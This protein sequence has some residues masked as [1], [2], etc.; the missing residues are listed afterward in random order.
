MLCA[1]LTQLIELLLDRLGYVRLELVPD[2]PGPPAPRIVV[3]P[4]PIVPGA[5][6][7]PQPSVSGWFLPAVRA[8]GSRA[9]A[10]TW[11]DEPKTIVDLE[12]PAGWDEDTEV[13]PERRIAPSATEWTDLTMP[14]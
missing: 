9:E 13:D 5:P 1:C 14:E 3:P 6:R 11:V 8:L 7:A 12:P 2:L 4:P 10:D